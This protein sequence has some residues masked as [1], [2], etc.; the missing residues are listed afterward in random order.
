MFSNIINKIGKSFKEIPLGIKLIIF[1]IFLWSFG[2]GFVDPYYSIFI[3]T[4]GTSYSLLGLFISLMGVISLITIIPLI[5]LVDKVKDARIMEDGQILYFFAILTYVLAGILKSIPLLVFAMF[6]NG[7]AHP[8][9]V[10]GAES[11]IRKHSKKLGN[12]IA[13]GYYTT[14]E[15]TGWILGMIIAAFLIKYINLNLMF[16]FV[17][18]GVIS[19]FFLLPRIKEKGIKSFVKGLTMYFHKRQDFISIFSDIK[20][21]DHKM[22]FLLCLSFF[23][24]MVRMLTRVF[25]P[26]LAIAIGLS[27]KHIAILMAIMHIPYIFSF[28]FS[29]ITDNVPKM[30]VISVSLFVGSIS[31][32]A[33]TFAGDYFWIAVFASLN[34]AAIAFIRPAYNGIIT[35]LTPNSMLGTI[36]G[37]NK[38]FMKLGAIIGPL[39]AGIVSDYFGIEYAFLVFA[40]IF[41]LFGITAL[42]LHGYDSLVVENDT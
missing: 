27:L 13:F 7:I 9:V 19:S 33:L 5:R 12:S 10:V 34:S 20:N 22:T 23:D 2:W 31:L 40:V 18:P 37:I 17:L 30:N 3:E 39:L 26:L 36:T 28:I 25:I 41:A 24:G 14:F 11:Y 42:F 21:L 1:V 4:F 8:F 29:K 35:H 38:L 15:Y 6:L 16:L 32:L